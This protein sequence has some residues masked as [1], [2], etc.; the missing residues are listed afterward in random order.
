MGKTRSD[1]YKLLLGDLRWTQEKTFHD[2]NNHLLGKVVDSLQLVTQD[3]AGLSWA[4]HALAMG[5]MQF[6]S[7]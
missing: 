5:S 6:L 1:S 7:P 4:D 3:L 2:E